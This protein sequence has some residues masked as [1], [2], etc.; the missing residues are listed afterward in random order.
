MSFTPLVMATTASCSGMHDAELPERPIAPI[1]AVAAAPE[2]VAVALI[3]IALRVAA[4][5]GLPRGGRLDPRCGDELLPVPFPLLEVELAELGDVLGA[6][7]QAVAAGRD[8]LR[9]G[10]PG[11]VLDAQRLEESRPQVIE[12]GHARRL[13]DDGR[14]HVR[15]RR[16]VQEMRARLERHGLRQEGLGPVLVGRA[17]RLGLMARG[18]A[19]QVADAH[20]LQV[21]ARLGRGIVGE[22]FQHLVVKAQLPFRD[23]QADGGRGEALAQRV[24]RVRR[25]GVIGRPPAL[26]HDVPVAHQHEAVHRVDLS[27]ASTNASTPEDE[28]PC[29]SGLLR[30]N[31]EVDRSAARQEETHQTTRTARVRVFMRVPRRSSSGVSSTAD[32]R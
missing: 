30:G 17:R 6:D 22:E 28:T 25:L 18:H 9:A 15:R 8:A 20:R 23:G 12:Y 14:E 7:A 11:R 24:Q 19:Q 21:V 4:V 1:G 26:G 32:F 10:L 31:D 13:L 5:G 29:D 2:L 27:A 16:V 3:P